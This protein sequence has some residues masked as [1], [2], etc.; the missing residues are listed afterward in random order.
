MKG[1]WVIAFARIS[2]VAA[3]ASCFGVAILLLRGLLQRKLDV[4]LRADG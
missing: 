1:D 2:C 3:G 4:L